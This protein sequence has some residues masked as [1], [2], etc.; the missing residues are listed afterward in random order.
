[1]Y[2]KCQGRCGTNFAISMNLTCSFS[3]P[4][5]CRVGVVCA[6]LASPPSSVPARKT[7][8]CWPLAGCWAWCG[9]L[10]HRARFF[11]CTQYCVVCSGKI[12]WVRTERKGKFY[13]QK[14][15]TEDCLLNVWT[16]TQP[17]SNSSILLTLRSLLERRIHFVYWKMLSKNAK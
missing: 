6:H 13:K 5:L 2:V 15:D 17:F 10:V 1:M 11:S 4:P 12:S 14:A 9:Q 3:L 7:A 8:Q 16:T